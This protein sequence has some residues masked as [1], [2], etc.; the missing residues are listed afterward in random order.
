MTLEQNK[1]ADGSDKIE[2]QAPTPEE[3][4]AIVSPSS[5]SEQLSELFTP[6]LQV[7]PHHATF[8]CALCSRAWRV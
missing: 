6:L 8:Y 1:K 2:D 4:P 5:T 3:N 7:T